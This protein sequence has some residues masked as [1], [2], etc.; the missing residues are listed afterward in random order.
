MVI[1]VRI[2]RGV[3]SLRLQRAMNC[4]G[5]AG[6]TTLTN[7]GQPCAKVGREWDHAW[8]APRARNKGQALSNVTERSNGVAARGVAHVSLEWLTY[9]ESS[10]QRTCKDLPRPFSPSA[11]LKFEKKM[12]SFRRFSSR[13]RKLCPCVH[14]RRGFANSRC[15]TRPWGSTAAWPGSH[16]IR[17]PS[18]RN[19]RLEP[20]PLGCVLLEPVPHGPVDDEGAP[21][22]AVAK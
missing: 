6:P 18:L 14:L 13:R 17:R 4:Q 3:L 11:L 16:L 2:C 21:F 12:E 8:R 19:Q 9:R 15:P 10:W 7:R 20:H 1:G 5:H 22:L